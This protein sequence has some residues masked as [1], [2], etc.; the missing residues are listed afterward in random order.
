MT[1][2]NG[3]S[4]VGTI[5]LTKGATYTLPIVRTSGTGI[6]NFTTLTWTFNIYTQSDGELFSD[7]ATVIASDADNLL[8]TIPASVTST[9]EWSG[10]KYGFTLKGVT[11]STAYIPLKGGVIVERADG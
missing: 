11:G 1:V 7:D 6:P 10:V 2:L 9:M 5:K 4:A 8:I 3:N